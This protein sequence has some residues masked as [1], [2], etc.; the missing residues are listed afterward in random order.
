MK[1]SLRGVIAYLGYPLLVSWPLVVCFCALR[2][3]SMP[4]D[5]V[6]RKGVEVAL[7]LISAVPVV[8]TLTMLERKMPYWPERKASREDVRND[9]THLAMC[10]FAISPIAQALMRV[11]ALTMVGTFAS[12]M[13]THVWPS[14]WP[15][16]LQLLLAL[17]IG[18]F[19]QYWFH[20]LGHETNL[21]WR[22]HATHHGTPQVYWLNS[23]RFHAIEVIVRT[24]FQT[25]PL[26][27][28]GCNADTF[29]IYGAFTAIHG[30]VQHSNVAWKTGF[31]N[32][33]LA[34]SDNHRWHHS[35]TVSEANHNYGLVLLLWDR[36]F[37]TYYSPKDRRFT[38]AV[39]IGDMP[40][41][42]RTYWGQFLTPFKWNELPRNSSPSSDPGG[43]SLQDEGRET[44]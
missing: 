27:I 20:R 17:A 12:S 9:L 35:T 22:V 14:H 33:I 43:E 23:T 8:I 38:G 32:L 13:G 21:A 19:G 3:F 11:L 4:E 40:D 39:G 2:V 16:L 15:L 42:P 28:L 6:F 31:F 30:W 29:L 26:I 41:F 5:P 24:M 10:W 44:A 34:T 37:G 25:A 36:V 7:F 1:S 18:E